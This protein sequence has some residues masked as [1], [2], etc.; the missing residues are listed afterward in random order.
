MAGVRRVVVG[1]LIGAVVASCGGSDGGEEDGDAGEG[2]ALA[3]TTAAAAPATT[4]AV[5]TTPA[6]ATVATSVDESVD[7]DASAPTDTEVC[8]L[9]DGDLEGCF[10]YD[11]MQA[12][13]DE[14]IAAVTSFIDATFADP[15]PMQPAQWIF[16]EEGATGQE[17]CTMGEGGF[18]MYTDMS[19]EYC[20]LDQTVYVG[21]R[22]VWDF[23][24][25]AGDAGAV[26]GMAHEAAHHMQA[27]AGVGGEG[28]LEESIALEN[29]ADCVAGAFTGW[30]E[31]E[32]LLDYPDDFDDIDVMMTLIA[33]AEEDPTHDHGTLEERVDAFLLGYGE[34]LPAC[35]ALFPATPLEPAP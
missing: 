32:G 15:A 11:G 31:S 30:L 4:I 17:P 19:Y 18:A 28:T 29:Q 24:E 6:E 8:P 21:Q 23:Y 9:T 16:V 13:Y 12:F 1:I 5:E 2:D 26:I 10:D 33:S 7:P 27:V 25:Q 14:G 35:S 22:Q 3:D 20:P 34:G